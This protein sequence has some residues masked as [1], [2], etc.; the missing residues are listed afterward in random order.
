MSH[1]EMEILIHAFASSRLDYCNALYTSLTKSS[2]QD[3]QS[4]HNAAAARLLTKSSK[5]SH[6]TPLLM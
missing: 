2:L 4:V 6:A 1:H 3:L 5:F